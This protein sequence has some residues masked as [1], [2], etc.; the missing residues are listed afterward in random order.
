MAV[1]LMLSSVRSKNLK[2]KCY[3]SGLDRPGAG[4]GDGDGPSSLGFSQYASSPTS[5]S[6]SSNKGTGNSNS[7]NTKEKDSS[8]KQPEKES[9]KE[10]VCNHQTRGSQSR[11][12][13]L[14]PEKVKA[15]Q[16][17]ETG[18]LE[19]D[20]GRDG[21]DDRI[22]DERGKQRKNTNDTLMDGQ[23]TTLNQD[24]KCDVLTEKMSSMQVSATRKD[25]RETSD[26]QNAAEVN[27][28]SEK[29]SLNSDHPIINTIDTSRENPLADNA[30]PNV[31]EEGAVG[32]Y[33]MS[34]QVVD[35]IKN[36][37]GSIQFQLKVY[38]IDLIIH[39]KD[40]TI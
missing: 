16:K 7:T 18:G 10:A 36:Q 26:D 22:N 21:K 9:S 34:N 35:E 20:R 4:D 33:S 24:D 30:T 1:H 5:D 38:G 15:G 27:N 32:L 14:D 37:D 3:V 6:K 23:A 19:K 13:S 25:G 12:G 29:G 28:N 40:I 8:E 2:E 31:Q 39:S 11:S 17:E